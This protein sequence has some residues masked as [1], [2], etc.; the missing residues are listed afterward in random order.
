MMLSSQARAAALHIVLL[1]LE[2][3]SAASLRAT[4]NVGRTYGGTSVQQ[5]LGG[6]VSRHDTVGPIDSD[7]T[8]ML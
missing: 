4:G 2:R 6:G 1:D 5:R 7:L 3:L 8:T